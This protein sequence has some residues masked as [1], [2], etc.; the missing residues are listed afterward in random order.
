MK[1]FSSKWI[2]WIKTFISGGS[3]A[4]SVN[5]DIGHYFQTKKAFDKEIHCHLFCLISWL[6]C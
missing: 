3:V 4:V 2:S 1:G 6:T 5:D